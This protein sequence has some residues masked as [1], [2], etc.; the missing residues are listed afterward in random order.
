MTNREYIIN[1]LL[2]GLENEADFERVSIDDGGA[3][4]E[5]M[6]YDNIACPYCAGDERC[7][8]NG[9]EIRRENCHSCK[10]EWLDSE[11]EQGV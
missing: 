8:C 3:S 5:A 9:Y 4:Y 10:E 1:L 7:H 6:V 11:V 2:D